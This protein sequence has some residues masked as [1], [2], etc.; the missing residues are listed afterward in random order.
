MIKF[1][2][3]YPCISGKMPEDLLEIHPML[4]YEFTDEVLVPHLHGNEHSSGSYIPAYRVR[5]RGNKRWEWSV[6]CKPLFWLP[7]PKLNTKLSVALMKNN[8]IVE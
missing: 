6:K 7:I 3:W 8:E 2:Y 5:K 4:D 1:G